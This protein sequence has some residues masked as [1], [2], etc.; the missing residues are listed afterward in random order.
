MLGCWLLILTTASSLV[1]P[2]YYMVYEVASEVLLVHAALYIS[3]NMNTLQAKR[4]SPLF[5]GGAQAGAVLGG[6][7]LVFGAPRLGAQNLL[8]RITS[9]NV[10][11]TKLLRYAP[12]TDIPPP[13]AADAHRRR[14]CR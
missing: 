3:Q 2:V 8:L 7:L 4:L 1:Y 5:Y 10:C 11:Y 9:Y 12:D 6:L 13:P 14:D